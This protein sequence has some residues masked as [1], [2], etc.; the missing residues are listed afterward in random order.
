MAAVRAPGAIPLTL[1]RVRGHPD[2]ASAVSHPD[3]LNDL[4]PHDDELEESDAHRPIEGARAE[5]PVDDRANFRDVGRGDVRC[6]YAG[7]KKREE[8]EKE[9]SQLLV[10]TSTLR[11]RS[12]C[13]SRRRSAN[14]FCAYCAELSRNAPL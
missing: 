2:G 7:R 5:L 3:L 4:R 8:P 1:H 9:T 14:T 13:S 10:A 12:S 6:G 11:S